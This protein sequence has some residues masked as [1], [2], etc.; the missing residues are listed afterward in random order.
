MSLKRYEC[1][2]GVT[3]FQQE[4][5]KSMEVLIKE[6]EVIFP[7]NSIRMV[8]ESC[9]EVIRYLLLKNDMIRDSY[10]SEEILKKQWF[11]ENGMESMMHTNLISEKM[12]EIILLKKE[13]GIL[14]ETGGFS[15]KISFGN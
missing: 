11:K 12:G 5:E 2:Y 6:G 9:K 3:P 8:S 7:E 13:S 4:E 10:R 14:M 1:L 15:D